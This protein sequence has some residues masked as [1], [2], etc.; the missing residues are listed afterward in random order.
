MHDI[1]DEIIEYIEENKV[2]T[3][4]VADVLNKTGLLAENIKPLVPRKRAVGRLFYA[5]IFNESN[6]YLHYFI[7][8]VPKRH[9]I[10]AEN[11]SCNNRAIFGSLVAKYALLYKRANGIVTD[12][13]VR[14][15]H[16]L[17]KE[18]YPIWAVGVTPIGCVNK[19]TGIDQEYYEKRKKE[20]D[21]SIIVADDSGV[22][23]VKKE[24]LNEKFLEGLK[25][26]E[27]Q[28]DVWFDCIDR[29]KYSTFETVCLRKYENE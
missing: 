12:G 7:Q 20:L 15:A 27:E 21:G 22:V 25:K 2:S 5:P 11:V 9:I 24:Q 6:W 10:Y 8:N 18:D 16:T 14:D 1:V 28:E 4:E 3:T 17:I 13:Y 29:R 26:I 23:L 19:N